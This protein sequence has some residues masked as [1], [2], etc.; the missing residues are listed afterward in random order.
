MRRL[1]MYLCQSSFHTFEIELV[2]AQVIDGGANVSHFLHHPMPGFLGS[3]PSHRASVHL[4]INPFQLFQR[5]IKRRP[6]H[7]SPPRRRE[8]QFS[9]SALARPAPRDGRAESLSPLYL[10]TTNLQLRG[11]E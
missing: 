6:F 4:A 5:F 7:C 8:N 2:T 10:A 9:I 3:Q 1:E 11:S